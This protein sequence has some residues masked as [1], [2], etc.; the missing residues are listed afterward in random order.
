MT[1]SLGAALF[2]LMIAMA[3][4][5]STAHGKKATV[6]GELGKLVKLKRGETLVFPEFQM[7]FDSH[8]HKSVSAGQSSPLIVYLTF[9]TSKR[10]EPFPLTLD[11]EDRGTATWKWR[12]YRFTLVGYDYNRW[13]KLIVKQP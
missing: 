7:T 3:G 1:K 4:L 12:K 5:T 8:S 13:M 6:H 11:V 2:T 10:R 9:I